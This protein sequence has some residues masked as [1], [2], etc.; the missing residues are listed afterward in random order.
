MKTN[1]LLRVLSL[2]A[3]L[4]LMAPFYDSCNGHRMKEAEA[5]DA[6]AADTTAVEVDNTKID[7]TEIAKTE[8]DTINNSVENYEL[9]FVDKA[10]ESIDDDDSENAFEFAKLSIDSI[11]EFNFKDFKKGV[12]DEGYGVVFFELKNFCFILIVVIT[13]LI[14][15]FSFKNSQRVY[16]LSKY[17]LVLLL[18]T[19]ICLFLEGLFETISQIKWGYYA[20]IIT[21]LIIFYYSKPNKI[22]T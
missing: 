18:I 21:N 8:I 1:R 5:V 15:V 22:Q 9:S 19:I 13:L 6:V 17:N 4:L 2:L 14:A 10:Y 20:F 16:K 7:S 3:F 11:L 12:K